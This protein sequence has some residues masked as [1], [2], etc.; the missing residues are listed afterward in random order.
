[1]LLTVTRVWVDL[2]QGFVQWEFNVPPQVANVPTG[3]MCLINGAWEE[4]ADLSGYGHNFIQL[5]YTDVTAAAWRLVPP[6]GYVTFS[7]AT[8]LA[9]SGNV[10]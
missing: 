10:N 8:V 5:Y 9:Q 4:P 3:L 6:L 7:G 1:M 2:D